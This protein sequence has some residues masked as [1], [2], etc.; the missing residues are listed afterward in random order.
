M[1]EL[2]HGV[3]KRIADLK[4]K[5]KA[6]EGKKEYAENNAAIRSEIARLEAITQAKAALVASEPGS[7]DDDKSEDVT[8]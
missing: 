7:G 2:I 3:P 8:L 1:L 6:R 5:L 4:R